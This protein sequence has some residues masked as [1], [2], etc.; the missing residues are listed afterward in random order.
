MVVA[1]NPLTVSE[2]RE[3][4]VPVVYG[5][6]GSAA[7]LA[8]ARLEEAS[9][10]AVLVHDDVAAEMAL[11]HA[12]AVN[13]GRDIVA[14]AGSRESI[15]KLRVAGASDVVQPEFG[16]GVEVIQHVFQRCEIHG[17]ELELL[18]GERGSACYRHWES[19][20]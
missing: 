14:R 16:A 10:L 18:V 17:D 6:A 12:R 4:D 9:L 11:H 3:K 1:Y 15:Q 8:H 19:P 5:D 13:P 2:S 7:V 20:Q